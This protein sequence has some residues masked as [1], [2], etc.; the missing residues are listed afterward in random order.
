MLCPICGAQNASQKTI[1]AECDEVLPV[2]SV[3]IGPFIVRC[4]TCG[5]QSEDR[6]T[7]CIECGESLVDE[8][9]ESSPWIESLASLPAWLRWIVALPVVSIV[10]AIAVRLLEYVGLRDPSI[11]VLPALAAAVVIYAAAHVAAF[12]APSLRKHV[13]LVIAVAEVTVFFGVLLSVAMAGTDEPPPLVVV[14]YTVIPLLGLAAAILSLSRNKSMIDEPMRILRHSVPGFDLGWFVTIT[15][16]FAAAVVFNC[17]LVGVN[18]LWPRYL[19]V[20]ATQSLAA[21]IESWILVT[22]V[23]YFAPARNMVAARV[24]AGTLVALSVLGIVFTIFA[25]SRISM[26][27]V[28]GYIEFDF[29]H[30]LLMSV[31]MISGALL[32][33]K[34]AV[35]V[36]SEV[37]A[38]EA[39]R[40]DKDE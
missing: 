21:V 27:R 23:A 1:C 13:G 25:F 19:S 28:P 26:L 5:A 39:A 14:L 11:V 35:L 31:A 17:F 4:A 32:G 30:N 33:L 3:E 22:F 16:A 36:S 7:T 40:A 24:A 9:K 6:A 12:A 37:G 8:P 20:G 15:G 38:P 18:A 10:A 2:E 29:A 34:A